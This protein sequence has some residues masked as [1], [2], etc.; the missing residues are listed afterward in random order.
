MD[1]RVAD[2]LED[3]L[4]T[5]ADLDVAHLDALLARI[6]A[7]Q[8]TLKRQVDGAQKDLHDAKQLAHSRHARLQ[9]RATDFHR[10]QADIDRRLLVI[11]ASETSDEAVPRFDALLD[12]LHRLDVAGGYVELLAA[13]DVL[14]KHAQ[15]QLLLSHDAALEPYKQ[16]RSLHTRLLRLQDD[17]E[18]AAPQLLHHIDR[19]TQHLRTRILDALS[20]DLDRVLK[21][22]RWPTP[23]A[24]IPPQ[25]REEW[26]T[27][28][29]KLLDLQMPE[30]DGM[31]YARRPGD[32]NKVKLPPVLFPFEVMVQPLEGS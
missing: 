14:S 21:K 26:E 25:L 30:L 20:S 6:T 27:A 11:T 29:V 32:D 22:I 10:Q 12:T 18:G 31:R 24:V 19:I 4:Q 28:V 5:A 16:L 3:Q 8:A 2:F 7:Q 17:A 15:S 1:D 23:K 13:V 9:Q